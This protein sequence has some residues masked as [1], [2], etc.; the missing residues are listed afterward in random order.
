MIDLELKKYNQVKFDLDFT[1]AAR[2]DSQK[3]FICPSLKARRL[4]DD[5]LLDASEQL[6]Y[7]TKD[8][9]IFFVLAGRDM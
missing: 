3:T 7:N 1:L 5:Y 8:K 6:F 2:R 4:L 9:F